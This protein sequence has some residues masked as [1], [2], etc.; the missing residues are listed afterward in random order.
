MTRVVREVE[1]VS[2]GRDAGPASL[3]PAGLR[4]SPDTPAF[5]RPPTHGR[6]DEI[7]LEATDVATVRV[8][9]I[10]PS[11]ATVGR[12]QT[13]APEFASTTTPSV[14]ARLDVAMVD[15]LRRRLEPRLADLRRGV[16]WEQADDP[17]DALRRTRIATRRLRC[18]A[19]LFEPMIGR[20]RAKPLRKRLRTIARGIG[21]LRDWDALISLLLAEHGKA[22]PLGRAALEMVLVWA[23]EQRESE[24]PRARTA[25]AKGQLCE[26]ANALDEELDRVCGRIMRL[27]EGLRRELSG[28]LTPVVD[29]TITAI[30]ALGRP[31]DLEQLHDI[32]LR[33][34]RWRYTIEMLQ[35][36]TGPAFNSLRKPAKRLQRALG[37]HREISILLAMLERHA[38]GLVERELPTLADALRSMTVDLGRTQ[39]GAHGHALQQLDELSPERLPALAAAIWSGPA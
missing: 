15:N 22:E 7:H 17:V 27:D 1:R 13:T 5:R 24:V 34:K 39:R 4:T 23:R 26:L 18:F 35:P 19:E 11:A 29:R 32:R 31:Q 2:G 33:A 21:P 3:A 9:L 28:L 36:L 6:T 12:Q 38:A 8:E 14:P 10:G 30:P 37:R 25:I 20:E 16:E